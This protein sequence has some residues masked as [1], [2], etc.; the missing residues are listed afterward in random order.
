MRLIVLKVLLADFKE[1]LG[2]NIAV[3]SS[4]VF[5]VT[6]P[7]ELKGTPDNQTRTQQEII[8]G[9]IDPNV[10]FDTVKEDWSEYDVEGVRV[11]TKTIATIIA[12]SKYFD[13][14]GDPIYNVTYQT[15]MKPITSP[16]AQAKFKKIWTERRPKKTA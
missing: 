11:E 7:K 6:P 4:L 16:E 1:G 5:T 2:A 15:I 3:G 8:A 9:I 14:V 12:K 10:P 13:N